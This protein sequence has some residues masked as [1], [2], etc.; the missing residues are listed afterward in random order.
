MGY[1]HYWRRTALPFTDADWT[2][3]KAGISLILIGATLKG[4]KLTGLGEQPFDDPAAIVG[5]A[6]PGNEFIVFNGAGRDAHETFLLEQVNEPELEHLR[7]DLD[8][9][10]MTFQFCKT[11]RKPYDVAVVAALCYLASE[12]P[13]H[14]TRVASDGDAADWREGLELAKHAFRSAFPIMMP[15]TVE[16]PEGV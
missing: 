6:R 5:C 13:G 1:T 10:G 7:A 16:N 12:Y 15:R 3:V 9:E 4:V 8:N 2:V 11:A 14:V